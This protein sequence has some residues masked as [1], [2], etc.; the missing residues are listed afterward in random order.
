MISFLCF[1]QNIDQKRDSIIQTGLDYYFKRDTVGLK[2]SN[3]LLKELY[4][5]YG[6][7]LSL[8]KIYH[9]K[10]LKFRIQYRLDS[11]YYYYHQSKDIS[12][13]INDSLEVGRRLL[14][15][16]Y[17][18][19]DERD[20]VGAKDV[21]IET[22]R[23][24]E[25]LKEISYTGDGY[26]ILGNILTNLGE[27]NEARKSYYKSQEI[28]KLHKNENFKEGW[29]LFLLNNIGNTYLL[30]G[31]HTKAIEY[32]NLGLNSI[33]DKE[34]R[35]N[36]YILLLGN[37]ADCLYEIDEKQEAW[38]KYLLI[39]DLRE[40][41][42][43]TYGLSLSHNG[44]SQRFLEEGNR[45][46]AKY[47]A[48][49]GYEL[50]KKVNNNATRLSAL[51]KLGELTNGLQSKQYYQE[52]AQLNDS[53]NKRERYLKG[54]FALVRYETE[55]KDKQNEKLRIDKEEQERETERQRQQKLISWLA[56]GLAILGLGFSYVYF[57]ARRKKLMY[58]AQLQ[59]ASVREEERQQIAKSLHDEVAGDLR[60][61]HQKLSKTELQKEADNL[62]KI[63]EN[64]RNL[65]HQLSS[66]SFDE[67]SFKDQI[68]NLIADSFS[69][70]FR[71]STEG[72]NDIGWKEIN[73]T[74][75]RTLYLCIR[76]SL[77]NTLKYAEASKFFI[78]FSI[79]K[80]EIVLLLKDN[81][82][83]FDLTKGKK[84]IGLK[85]LKERAEEIHGSFDIESSEEGTKTT[86]RIPIHGR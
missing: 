11:S 14:S 42:K 68:V 73:N 20:Y 31:N 24:L 35:F 71:I 59:K 86:I 44:L 53:L 79:E 78:H 51:L 18:Q 63:K 49:K 39:L 43:N 55:K 29:N 48:E 9:F 10:A 50:A 3:I 4:E 77:Q 2:E 81:G 12:K 65:S 85:N 67:V 84:G 66:V 6:D 64:V 62:E 38:E 58:E 22:L 23:Y 19:N 69:P 40:K 41:A 16:A 45:I 76:E 54:Q 83:G 72:I 15:M 26:N 7:S 74:L 28:F 8:A 13:Q 30:E 46:K 27:Y 57:R 56:S 80:K 36:Q 5:S 75:K 34:K 60:M 17:M 33:S 61:L 1:G 21:A 47:H 32:L 52:Y 25:P 70:S 37:L 82:K